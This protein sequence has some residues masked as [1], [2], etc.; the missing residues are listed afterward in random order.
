MS[1]SGLSHSNNYFWPLKFTI[2]VPI[3]VIFIIDMF[4]SNY[5]HM[6]VVSLIVQYIILSTQKFSSLAC[7]SITHMNNL[8]LLNL[9]CP[10]FLKWFV[11]TCLTWWLSNK[12]NKGILY[13]LLPT[14]RF[15][16]SCLHI[17]FGNC[18]SEWSICS[19]PPWY[20]TTRLL[21]FII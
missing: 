13:L 2:L 15:S 10:E 14:N 6:I 7:F 17:I 8:I 11:H 20:P 3:A 16:I 9:K 18:N 12:Q 19:C 4:L 1:W 21:F 5:F